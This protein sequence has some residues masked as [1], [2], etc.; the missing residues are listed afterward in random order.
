[1]LRISDEM[2]RR[3]GAS[4]FS[5]IVMDL[6]NDR[7]EVRAPELNAWDPQRFATRFKRAFRLDFVVVR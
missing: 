5:R 1:M 7:F 3:L 6:V 4:R 2:E